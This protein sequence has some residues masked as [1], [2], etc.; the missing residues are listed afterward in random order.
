MVDKQN[1]VA[2]NHKKLLKKHGHSINY[3]NPEKK[4]EYYI[5]MARHAFEV[6]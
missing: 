1:Q 2:L 3:P 5:N 6:R 4:K